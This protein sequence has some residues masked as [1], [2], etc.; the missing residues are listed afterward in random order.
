MQ[1]S[2]RRS[3]ASDS[4][5]SSSRRAR[6]GCGPSTCSSAPSR[7]T[8]GSPDGLR[9]TLPKV[10]DG[11]AGRGDG[12]RRRRS[13]ARPRPARR[14]HPVR[15][16]GRDRAGRAR[17]RRP[18]AAGTAARPPAPGA[19]LRSTSAPTSYTAALGIAARQ[20]SLDHPAADLGEELMQLAVAGTGIRLSDG[21][22]NILPIGERSVEAWMLHARLVRRSLERGHLPGLGS[23]P[24]PAAHPVPRHLR[25]LPGGIRG[26]RRAAALVRERRAGS[27]LDEPATARALAWFVL[28]GAQCG[29]IDPAEMTGDVGIGPDALVALAH[30]VRRAEESA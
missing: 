27:V 25:V 21:S 19:S 30:P 11:R 16:A 17:R 12:R 14:P 5:V 2:R 24:P 3:S 20:Q 15:G 7:R 9:L 10:L 29:A 23:P 22:T 18:R 26:C 1:G 28:R 4:R 8:A 13:G 6:E